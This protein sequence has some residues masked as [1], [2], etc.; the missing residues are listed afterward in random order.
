[1]INNKYLKLSRT[2]NKKSINNFIYNKIGERIID[3]I[4]LVKIEFKNI[5][6]LG[7]NDLEISE[8][9]RSRFKE[10]NFYTTDIIETSI[11][12]SLFKNYFKINNYDYDLNEN[13][14][15]LIYSNNFIHLF[16]NFEKLLLNIK[17]SLKNNGL[18][19]AA[20]PSRNN[21]YQMINSMYETDLELYGGAY[22]RA[23]PVPDLD[24]IISLLNKLKY[25]MPTINNDKF[26]IE[27]SNFSALINDLRS[28][29]LSYCYDD[30]KKNFENKRYFELLEKKYKQKYYYNK[31]FNLE[32]SY[33]IVTAWKN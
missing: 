33:N 10:A 27:Y 26:I 14:Y 23:N 25:Y 12:K 2:R 16:Q 20:I 13:C 5:L 15:D 19:I 18:L 6:E 9:L 7:I 1:M 30:K 22:T 28:T 24:L 29:R 17:S 11:Y 32:I 3:S 8:Y 31:K 4:D 21:A